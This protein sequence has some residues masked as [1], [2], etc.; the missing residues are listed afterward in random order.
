MDHSLRASEQDILVCLLVTGDAP[1]KLIADRTGRHSK[2]VSD[3]L[4]ELDSL[5]LVRNKGYGSWSL[6][7]DGVRYARAILEDRRDANLLQM[8]HGPPSDDS[9]PPEPLL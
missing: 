5:G 9:E 7:R 6:T 1:P 8:G 3:R 2:T 4:S